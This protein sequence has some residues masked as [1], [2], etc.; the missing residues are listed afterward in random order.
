MKLIKIIKRMFRD[1][2]PY[3]LKTQMFINMNNIYVKKEIIFA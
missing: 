2:I 1:E 3:I